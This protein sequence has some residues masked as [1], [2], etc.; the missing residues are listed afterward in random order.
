MLGQLYLELLRVSV[1]TSWTQNFLLINSLQAQHGCPPSA[2][3]MDPQKGA[4]YHGPSGP[5]CRLPRFESEMTIHVPSAVELL[6]EDACFRFCASLKSKDIDTAVVK[7]L[8]IARQVDHCG[9]DYSQPVVVRNGINSTIAIGVGVWRGSGKC[10]SDR[11][12]LG[13]GETR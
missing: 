4:F 5:W 12:M 9:S 1:N 10:L 6:R 7:G 11:K 13:N 3:W 8:S 2:L